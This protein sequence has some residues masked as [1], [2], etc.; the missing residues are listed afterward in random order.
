MRACVCV[1][2]TF[3]CAYMNDYFFSKKRPGAI[4]TIHS[5][6]STT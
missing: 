2:K 3:T 4:K 5:P 6:N 1:C